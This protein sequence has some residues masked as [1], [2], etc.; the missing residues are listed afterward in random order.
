MTTLLSVSLKPSHIL[1]A[2]IITASLLRFYNLTKLPSSLNLDEVAIGYNAYSILKTGQ[3]EYGT[4]WPIAFRSHDDYK[5][6]LYIYLTT[7]PIAIFGL[8]PLAVR[9]WSSFAGSVSI[10][11]F[12]FLI[13][14]LFK[15][16]KRAT[17]YALI[18]SFLLAISPWHIQFSRAAFETNLSLFLILIGIWSF[19]KGRTQ[20]RYWIFTATSFALSLHA[21]HATK[22][23]VPI[24]SIFLVLTSRKII[25]NHTTISFLSALLFIAIISPL[26]PFSLSPEG[27]LRFKG[28]NVF[29]TPTLVESNREQK[30]V[31]IDQGR[32]FEAR[33][34]HNQY[35]AR[36]LTLSRGYFSH[37]SYDFL[38]NESG[39]PKNYTLNVGLLYLWQLPLI[40]IG[41][42]SLF[43]TKR[44]AFWLTLTWLLL[45]PVASS[46]TWDV[47]SSTRTLLMLPPLILLTAIGL[48]TFTR[49]NFTAFRYTKGF[50]VA[51]VVIFS[52]FH[53]LHNYSRLSLQTYAQSWQFGYDQAVA[54]TEAHQANYA[55]I[56]VSTNLRQPQNFWAFYSVYDPRTY[57][58]VDGGTVSGGFNEDRNHF[59]KYYFHPITWESQALEQNALYVDLTQYIPSTFKPIHT[60]TLP[61]DSAYIS[62]VEAPGG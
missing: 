2:I 3:D 36:L 56:I 47:P 22:L 35:L 61:D 54:Y 26:I 43:H 40:F 32:P 11:V 20:P 8:T 19:L 50:F 30:V 31:E 15:P 16:S 39:P 51:I 13:L 41:G 62:I 44:P 23:F 37:Y 12:Y 57:I 14:E 24:F 59:G 58:N 29:S 27:Q 5:A 55:K 42:Y 48:A 46:L 7:I 10:P 18:S 1:V 33:L 60:I 28:T 45:A 34:F 52:F 21:Y 4:P 17:H 9:F 53:Y 6:P 38:F 49:S 25:L